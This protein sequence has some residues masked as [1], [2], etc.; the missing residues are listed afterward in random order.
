MVSVHPWNLGNFTDG[1]WQPGTGKTIPL[2]A[3]A[4]GAVIGDLAFAGSDAVD[5]AVAAADRAF[6]D[7]GQTTGAARAAIIERMADGIQAR[8]DDLIALTAETNG[9]PLAEATGDVEDAARCLRYYAGQ[10]R[11]LDDRQGQPVAYEAAF[12]SQTY[13]EPVGPVAAIL[14]WNFPLKIA[15]W[16]LGPALA[17][18]CTVVLKPSPQSPLAENVRG[19]VGAEAG[20][21]PGVL[22]IVHGDGDLVGPKLT[23]DARVAKISFT[24]STAVGQAL[25]RGAAGDLKRLGL[26]LGGKSP[27]IVF[28]DADPDLAVRLIVEGVF[29]NAGQCCNATGRLLVEEAIAPDILARLKAR[30]GAMTLGAPETGAEM[31]PVISEAQYRRI[32]GFLDSAK[33]EGLVPLTGGEVDAKSPGFFVPPTVYTDVPASS[34]L[35]TEEIFGPVLAAATFRD[36]A[37]AIARANDTEYGLAATI[38]T[39]DAARG[40]RVA[41]QIQAGH[42]YL[43][44]SVAIPPETMWGGFKKSG[45]GRELGP[46]GLQGYLEPKT[47]TAPK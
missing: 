28:A 9:K 6:A 23:G 13:L 12:G 47:L 25:M 40:R 3:P 15:A 38:V 20:L 10:A 24:G 34:R 33:A 43:N 31:G 17:A 37:E 18:G 2:V 21:P 16:K 29:Y 11:A 1:A 26:E 7:W 8:R 45:L 35:W 36:E 19:V 42:I 14:P 39:G 4:T 32:R 5:A 30:V 22:N 44:T 46:W 41:R 27:I